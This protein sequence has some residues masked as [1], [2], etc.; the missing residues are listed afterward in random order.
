VGRQ[1]KWQAVKVIGESDL[2]R[3]KQRGAKQHSVKQHGGHHNI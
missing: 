3:A 2:T 1:P